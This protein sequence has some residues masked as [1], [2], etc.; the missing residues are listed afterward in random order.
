MD[1]PDY[2]GHV[3]SSLLYTYGACVPLLI[4]SLFMDFFLKMCTTSELP[5]TAECPKVNSNYFWFNVFILGAHL[6][7]GPNEQRNDNLLQKLKETE[8]KYH[9]HQGRNEINHE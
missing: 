9:N 1:C 6:R 8:R 4:P 3:L 2:E 5:L 7:H